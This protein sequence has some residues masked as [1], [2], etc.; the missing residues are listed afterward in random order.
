VPSP[1]LSTTCSVA[2]SFPRKRSTTL[3]GPSYEGSI[4]SEQ[5]KAG[6]IRRGN[7]GDAKIRVRLGL[8]LGRKMSAAQL[9]PRGC[10]GWGNRGMTIERP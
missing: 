10:G 5:T 6:K 7:S 9:S 3:E 1:G 4:S 8:R 2:A